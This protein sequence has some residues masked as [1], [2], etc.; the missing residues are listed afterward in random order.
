[1]TFL[2]NITDATDKTFQQE[3]LETKGLVLVDFWASWCGPCKALAPVIEAL[4]EKYNKLKI[5]KVDVDKNFKTAE[6]Y[7]V[8]GIPTLLFFY[9]GK[10][11]NTII[12]FTDNK[13]IDEVINTWIA[14]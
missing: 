1:M 7:D 10:L 12:G 3:V 11:V 13:K 2:N 8:R 9:D 5:V 4:A 6:Q 14:N